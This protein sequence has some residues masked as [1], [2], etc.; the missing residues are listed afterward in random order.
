MTW[1]PVRS[2]LMAGV[3]VGILVLVIGVL[4]F[5]SNQKIISIVFDFW[6][7]CSIALI[8]LGAAIIGGVL[9]ASRMMHGGWRKWAEPWE[10]A[11][12]EPREK[13]P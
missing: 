10:K 13:S 1:G 7:V 5:L 6:T 3:V 2:G 8:F 9:W 12:E 11:W 4:F